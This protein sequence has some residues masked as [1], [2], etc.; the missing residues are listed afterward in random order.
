MTAGKATRS[1]RARSPQDAAREQQKS[2]AQLKARLSK[3]EA[4]VERSFRLL[5]LGSAQI[6]EVRARLDAGESVDSLMSDFAVYRAGGTR[7]RA[8]LAVR[9]GVTAPDPRA[10]HAT[11]TR[12]ELGPAPRLPNHESSALAAK[13]G[14]T[15]DDE[16]SRSN[17]VTSTACKLTLGLPN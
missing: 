12:L 2:L 16:R 14:V 1:A 3:A 7:G 5:G 4:S 6:N 15:V 9:M 13:M 8:D 11:S 10:V 17:G